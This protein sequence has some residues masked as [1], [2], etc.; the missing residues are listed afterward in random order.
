MSVEIDLSG[1]V[2]SFDFGSF[3]EFH[4]PKLRGFIR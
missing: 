2:P 4:E 3:E 1:K